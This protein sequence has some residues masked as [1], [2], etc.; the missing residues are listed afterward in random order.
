MWVCG[1]CGGSWVRCCVRCVSRCSCLCNCSLIGNGLLMLVIILCVGRC[2]KG[3]WFCYG[4]VVVVVLW[5]LCRYCGI[6]L[7]WL[8]CGME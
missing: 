7:N 3:C 2:C 5:L 6:V 4:L 1:W 8:M